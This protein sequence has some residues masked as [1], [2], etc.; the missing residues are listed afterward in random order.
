[1]ALGGTLCQSRLELLLRPGTKGCRRGASTARRSLLG[2]QSTKSGVQV[3]G[4]VLTRLLEA[5]LH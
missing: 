4:R 1:M 5:H 2:P 3:R